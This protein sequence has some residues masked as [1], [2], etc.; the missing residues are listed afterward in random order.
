MIAATIGIFIISGILMSSSHREAPL[1]AYDPQADNKDVY[2]FR[3]PVNPGKI[4]IIANY[5]PGQ[6]PEDGPVYHNF[7]ENIRYE[8]HIKNNALTAGDDI[9]Y[10]FTFKKVDEDPTTFFHIRLEKE[11]QKATYMLEIE[12]RET[13]R[14]LNK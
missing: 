11:N 12:S 14:L 7:G 6:L 1:I 13:L 9:T 8:F 2:A 3:S 10:H 4:I 5:I